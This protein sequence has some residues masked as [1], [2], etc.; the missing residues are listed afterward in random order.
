MSCDC[1]NEGPPSIPFVA[2]ESKMT[3]NE[4]HIKRLIIVL[5]VEM[6]IHD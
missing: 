6:S 5:K 2:Y 4:R 1:K 3:R